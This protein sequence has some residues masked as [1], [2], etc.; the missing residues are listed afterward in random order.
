ML[1]LHR[2]SRYFA[3]SRPNV[4]GVSTSGRRAEVYGRA[5]SRDTIVHMAWRPGWV[6][7]FAFLVGTARRA[8][9]A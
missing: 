9:H 5:Y 6:P 2:L 7:R 8:S 4:S 3:V 1:L